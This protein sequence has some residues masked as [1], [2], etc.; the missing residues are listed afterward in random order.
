MVSF[1]ALHPVRHREAHLCA[2]H[3]RSSFELTVDAVVSY[4]KHK[5]AALIEVVTRT[6]EG[7][8]CSDYK[9][10]ECD[11][12]DEMIFFSVACCMNDVLRYSPLRWSAFR[13]YPIPPVPMPLTRTNSDIPA[14]CVLLSHCIKLVTE[15]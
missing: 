2:C 11:P 6:F 1:A 13:I 15:E 9:D 10:N 4:L 3:G 8:C 12:S 14:L 5:S 7:I